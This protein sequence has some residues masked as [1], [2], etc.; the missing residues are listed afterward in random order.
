MDPGNGTSFLGGHE[1]FT[2]SYMVVME[3]SPNPP[4]KKSSMWSG[5]KEGRTLQRGFVTY[6]DVWDGRKSLFGPAN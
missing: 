5:V 2:P 1:Y 4:R 6:F 3:S